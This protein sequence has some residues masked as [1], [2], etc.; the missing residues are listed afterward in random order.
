MPNPKVLI[1]ESRYESHAE[2]EAV[3]AKIGV[4]VVL[5]TSDDAATLARLVADIDALIVN[6]APITAEIIGAMTRCKCISRYG[7]GV[8]SV[9]VGAATAKGIAVLNVRDY[10]LEDVSDQ[11]LALLM[12][13]VRKTALTDRR[14]KAGE[15][16]IAAKKP[17]FRIAGKTLGL[18]GFGAIAR[19]MQRKV[20]GL[21][22][23]EVLV[24]DP[25]VPAEAVAKTGARKVALGE[26]L[27]TSDFVSVHAPLTDDT[28]G[29]IGAG[30]FK[31]MKATAIIVNTSRG[32]L[33][34][35][36]ALY[37][38]LKQGQ[39]NSAG[40]D[41]FSSEPPEDERKLFELENI[42]LSDHAGW[43]SEESQVDLQRSAAQNVALMLTG[44]PPLSC[45]NPEVL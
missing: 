25:Y 23:A 9:D 36:D 43:Y 8:D 39:I 44:K 12:A 42:V 22:L 33:I 24:Y 19:V 2:E 7:V 15:W 21:N 27:E 13:C 6:L 28:R 16:N 32:P 41:V 5:E 11:A 30:A 29:L 35:P 20:S 18:V 26:L 31:R 3:L 1:A 10:C 17:I 37:D 34:D 40:I 45:V 4:E 38:A 14:V